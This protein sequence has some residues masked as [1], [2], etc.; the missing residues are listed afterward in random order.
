M[1]LII[2]NAISNSSVQQSGEAPPPVEA[3]SFIWED[4]ENMV[5]EDGNNAITEG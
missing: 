3:F 5:W 1:M 2:S 4:S